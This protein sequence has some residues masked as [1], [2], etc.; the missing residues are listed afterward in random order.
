MVI[1]PVFYPPKICHYKYR[2]AALMIPRMAIF[3]PWFSFITY[4]EKEKGFS[5]V[6][7]KRQDHTYQFQKHSTLGIY[8]CVYSSSVPMIVMTWNQAKIW[9]IARIDNCKLR[10]TLHKINKKLKKQNVIYVN[11]KSPKTLYILESMRNIHTYWI[12]IL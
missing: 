8:I 1:F 2:I 6:C 4:I 12:K 3:A 9:Q 7:L 5:I 11:A 10:S